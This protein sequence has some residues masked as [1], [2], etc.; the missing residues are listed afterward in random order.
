MSSTYKERRKRRGLIRMRPPFFSKILAKKPT[1]KNQRAFLTTF[2][3][4]PCSCLQTVVL[5][6]KASGS[7]C[8][9]FRKMD[10]FAFYFFLNISWYSGIGFSSS[11][12]SMIFFHSFFSVLSFCLIY[13]SWSLTW[14]LIF[15]S[16]WACSGGVNIFFSFI[17]SS[18]AIDPV[19][20][21][22]LA[23]VQ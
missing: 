19:L 17:C 8:F 9:M 10:Y 4:H 5:S 3:K 14:L 13:W 11:L 2:S 16:S 18:R 6:R 22:L 20:N 21:R 15:S 12:L 23:A 1:R 7:K